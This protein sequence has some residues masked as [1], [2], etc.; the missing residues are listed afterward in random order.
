[1][2]LKEQ[3][4]AESKRERDAM[5][6]W[7]KLAVDWDDYHPSARAILD[8][9]FFW[10][11]TDDFSPNGNDTGADVLELYANWRKQ[12]RNSPAASFFSNLMRD[13]GVTEPHPSADDTMNGVWEEAKIGLAFAQFKVDGYCEDP[14]RF[15]ALESIALCRSR[16]TITHPNWEFL[17]ERIR[18]LDLLEG[19]L[20]QALS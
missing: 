16:I 5:D 10:D 14:V 17:G 7:E 12:A 18:T 20:R 4:D 11:R 1:M 8:K 6:E 19:K 9:P 3:L 13:W 2:A 15:A